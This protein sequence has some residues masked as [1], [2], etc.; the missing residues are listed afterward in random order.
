MLTPVAAF[1]NSGS[2]GIAGVQTGVKMSRRGGIDHQRVE[3]TRCCSA[4]R[5]QPP[6]CPSVV[7]A[8]QQGVP[9]ARQQQVAILRIDSD[10]SRATAERPRQLPTSNNRQPREQQKGDEAE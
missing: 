3:G 10:G 1:V 7:R 8:E 6:G 5:Q 9:R 2:N 4:E